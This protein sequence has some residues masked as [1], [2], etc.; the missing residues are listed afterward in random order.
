MGT[1]PS[2]VHKVNENTSKHNSKKKTIAKN[3]QKLIKDL[4]QRRLMTTK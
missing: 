3:Q 1:H 4:M 2:K